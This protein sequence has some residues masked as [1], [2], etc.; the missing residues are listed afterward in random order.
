MSEERAT[1]VRALLNEFWASN[2][3]VMERFAPEALLVDPL[4]PGPVKGKAEILRTFKLCHSWA[5]LH[6]ELHNVFATERFGAAEFT[7]RGVVQAPLDGLPDTVVG[8]PFE[9][10]EADIFQFDEQ[11]LVIRMSIYADV[12]H[13]NQQLEKYAAERPENK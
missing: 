2:W 13:F 1:Q 9:F 4:M 10:A 12:A 11:G 3:S 6:P 8:A 5:E 7:V